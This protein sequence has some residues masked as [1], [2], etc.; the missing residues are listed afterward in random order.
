MGALSLAANSTA[1]KGFGGKVKILPEVAKK[2]NLGYAS[3]ESEE[4]KAMS[5]LDLDDIEEFST[6]EFMHR[7]SMSRSKKPLFETIAEEPVCAR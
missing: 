4:K 1:K 6:L 5:K 2:A 3:L 7:L